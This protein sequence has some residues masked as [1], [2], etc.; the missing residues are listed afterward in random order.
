MRHAIPPDL[1]SNARVFGMQDIRAF[2]GIPSDYFKKDLIKL[3]AQEEKESPYFPSF[4]ND[5][6]YVL[7]AI[8]GGAA[9]GAYGA[10][11]LSGWSESGTRPVFKVVTGIST[12]AIMAPIAF[13]GSK[14][15]DKLK[16]F[17]TKYST[18]NIARIRILF[19]NSFADTR[20]LER[21]IERYFDAE[22]VKDVAVEYNKGRRLYIGTANLDAQRLVIWDMGKIA[23]VEMIKP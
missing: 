2:G 23:S 4:K 18:K 1:L 20:P 21:L 11:L 19:I 14:Y 3:F 7:L 22:L 17:Y 16:K 6:T 12:G 5:R 10:G 8:P 13:L 9:N 15:D